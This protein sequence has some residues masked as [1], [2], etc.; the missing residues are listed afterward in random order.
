MVS[1]LTDTVVSIF[2]FLNTELTPISEI[3]WNKVSRESRVLKIIKKEAREI[4]GNSR[5]K[6]GDFLGQRNTTVVLFQT[7]V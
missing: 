6:L 1:D 3:F 2:S 5:R 7:Q 4:V